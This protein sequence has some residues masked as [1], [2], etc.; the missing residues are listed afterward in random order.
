MTL[1]CVGDN[2]TV[3]GHFFFVLYALRGR[4]F[5]VVE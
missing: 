2:A 5:Y 4:F 1:D 3:K